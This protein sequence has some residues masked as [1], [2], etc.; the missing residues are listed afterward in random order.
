[1]S[2]FSAKQ[3]LQEKNIKY[4]FIGIYRCENIKQMYSNDQIAFGEKNL[5]IFHITCDSQDDISEFK[6]DNCLT[7]IL[8]YPKFLVH[9]LAVLPVKQSSYFAGFYSKDINMFVARRRLYHVSLLSL[10]YIR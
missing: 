4:L 1:M 2:S 8:K 3:T 9:V 6:A 7:R 5:Q 10:C